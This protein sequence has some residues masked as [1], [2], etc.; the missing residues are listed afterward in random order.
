[1]TKILI[2][3]KLMEDTVL[4]DMGPWLTGDPNPIWPWIL[5]SVVRGYHWDFVP[6]QSVAVSVNPPDDDFEF[7]KLNHVVKLCGTYAA[8]GWNQE[9]MDWP[10]W[11]KAT[12]ALA[13]STN[14]PTYVTDPWVKDQDG[15]DTGTK[16]KWVAW[17]KENR[18]ANGFT[19]IELNGAG[20][21][22]PG[23]TLAR[24]DAAGVTLMTP[25]EVL[26]ELG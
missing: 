3:K 6:G 11:I 22:E 17:G 10:C 14:V 21:I 20:V 19:Y 26:A 12:D 9:V 24:L 8:N 13:A 23:S 5:T 4:A 18:V 16:L 25:A 1:M 7:L 2:H 15:N